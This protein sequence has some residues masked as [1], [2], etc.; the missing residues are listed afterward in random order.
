L[1][2]PP[3]GLAL[4][5]TYLQ[6]S[7]NRRVL[8]DALRQYGALVTGSQ[9]WSSLKERLSLDLPH[10]ATDAEVCPMLFDLWLRSAQE[11][12]L[13]AERRGGA[14]LHFVQPNQY[15]SKHSF[16]PREQAVAL[17]LPP[18]H[19]YRRGV[20][21]GYALLAER[22]ATLNAN[23]IV[24]AIDLFDAVTEDVYSDNCCHY[25]ARGETLL[26]QFIAAQVEQRLKHGSPAGR[27]H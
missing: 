7:W 26:G 4:V 17:S 14:Y 9:N 10:Q 20:E 23:G 2:N 3:S 12:R 24:S 25:T 1:R 5:K 16:S 6:A 19:E 15:Y 18:E 11:M 8:S 22:R 13:L 21:L 27:G